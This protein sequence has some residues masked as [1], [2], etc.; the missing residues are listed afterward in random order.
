MFIPFKGLLGTIGSSFPSMP[1]QKAHWLIWYGSQIKSSGVDTSLCYCLWE[2]ENILMLSSIVEDTR[3]WETLVL[4]A[5][6]SH[7]GVGAVLSQL[8]E[9]WAD[10]PVA[11]FSW[12]PLP[13]EEQHSTIE[14][15]CLA[16]K[17][18]IHALTVYIVPAGTPFHY[19]DRSYNTVGHW[20]GLTGSKK[21]ML[22]SHN[23]ASSFSS[24]STKWNIE[25]VTGMGMQMVHPLTHSTANY[26]YM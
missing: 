12:K 7:R 19:S 15:E 22:D 17:L 25:Q 10:H 13:F 5:D 3:L 14:K 8:A 20:S 18:A 6:A 21:T 24:T 1:P 9:E 23:G 11:F 26:T 2:A 16:I 4:Q